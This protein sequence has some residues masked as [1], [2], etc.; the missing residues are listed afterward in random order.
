MALLLENN[1]IAS[2]ILTF[3]NRFS[4]FNFSLTSKVSGND[5]LHEKGRRL[6]RLG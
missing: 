1:L 4:I 2:K 5:L 6:L 3:K